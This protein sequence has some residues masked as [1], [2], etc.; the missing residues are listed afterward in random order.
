MK[1]SPHCLGVLLPSRTPTFAR[2]LVMQRCQD[3]CPQGLTPG[4]RNHHGGHPVLQANEPQ[5][6]IR[7]YGAWL[8]NSYCESPLDCSPELV[9][10]SGFCPSDDLPINVIDFPGLCGSIPATNRLPKM[11]PGVNVGDGKVEVRYLRNSSGITTDLQVHGLQ[12]L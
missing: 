5:R 11:P 6:A 8:N 10:V 2:R 3:S 7:M 9:L 1:G 12:A 4:V